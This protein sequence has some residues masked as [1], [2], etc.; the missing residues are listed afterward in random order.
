MATQH[1]EFPAHERP[2]TEVNSGLMLGIA[3]AFTVIWFGLLYT[4][5]IEHNFVRDLFLGSKLK[6]NGE[7]QRY[8]P[9]RLIFQGTITLV[10]ALSMA[11][12]ILKI[13]RNTVERGALDTTLLPQ[14]H[15]RLHSRP[16]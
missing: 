5:P 16:K 12:V 10:W 3:A 1:V 2:H 7:I 8:L 13:R 15:S 4:T 14:K 9:E 6:S 11:T